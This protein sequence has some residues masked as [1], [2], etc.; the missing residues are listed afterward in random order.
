MH[1]FAE[2]SPEQ[3]YKFVMCYQQNFIYPSSFLFISGSSAY[4]MCF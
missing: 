4:F 1:T 2:D 3:I